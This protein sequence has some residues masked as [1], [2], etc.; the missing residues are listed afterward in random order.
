M[1]TIQATAATVDTPRG[2]GTRGLL[3]LVAIVLGGLGNLA[4]LL[5]GYNGDHVRIAWLADHQ[6]AW[7][8]ATYGTA[9]NVLGILALLAA[10]CTLVRGRGA[11]WATV[12][13]AVGAL[14][15]ALYAVSAAI[16]MALLGLGTQTTVPAADAEALLEYVRDQDLTQVGVAFPGFLLLLVA[17]ITITVALVRS[18]ALPAW[19]PILFIVGGVLAV[20]FAGGGPLSAL[21]ALP[22]YV[23]MVAIGWHAHRS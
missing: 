16:P 1:T 3:L 9:L 18:R 19:V 17:Q 12:S 6:S 7:I 5:A 2:S 20:L 13:L 23:A 22:Q 4:N 11:A 8:A 10:V 14:G 15:T 21:L